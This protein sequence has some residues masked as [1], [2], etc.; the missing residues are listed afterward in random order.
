MWVWKGCGG[1][2]LGAAAS[3]TTHSACEQPAVPQAIRGGRTA[4][5]SRGGEPARRTSRRPVPESAVSADAALAGADAALRRL[6]P[7]CSW[8][9]SRNP[10]PYAPQS[11]DP[12]AAFAPRCAPLVLHARCCLLRGGGLTA[13]GQSPRAASR[14][15]GAHGAPRRRT[16]AACPCPAAAGPTRGGTVPSSSASRSP[17]GWPA[18]CAAGGAPGWAAGGAPG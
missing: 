9:S 18:A 5:Q 3:V 8:C 2:I 1:S 11:A 16:P 15:S 17:A 14:S 10:K 13:E 6:A 7:P 4:T 12:A